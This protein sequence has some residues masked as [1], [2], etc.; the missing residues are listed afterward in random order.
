MENGVKFGKPRKIKPAQ[1]RLVKKLKAEGK[2]YAKITEATGI[3]K[4]SLYLI[5]NPGKRKQYN[6]SHKI[7]L[8]AQRKS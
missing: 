7:Y 2:T 8:F 4:G 5:L 1:E 6:K 3:K